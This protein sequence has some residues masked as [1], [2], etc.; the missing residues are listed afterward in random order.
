MVAVRRRP[1]EVRDAI[2]SALRS[3]EAT[4]EQIQSKVEKLLGS[5]VPRSSVR[6]YLRLNEGTQFTRTARGRYRLRS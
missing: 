2:V 1:G 5:S 3:G 6:S 4:V